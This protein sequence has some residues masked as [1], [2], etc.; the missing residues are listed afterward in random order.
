MNILVPMAGVR[1]TA[2]T[3]GG[4]PPQLYE[5]AGKTIIQRVI[6]NL[7]TYGGDAR[8]IFI[9]RIEDCEKY[10]LHST[11]GLILGHKAKV[12]KVRGE[13]GGAACSA[14]LAIS[15]INNTSP[16]V[17]ANSD[18]ILD[19]NFSDFLSTSLKADAAVVTFSSVHPRWSYVRME[20]MKVT[21]AVEKYPISNHA[22]AGMYLF[23]E[24]RD[25][26]RAA[27]SSI[28]QH[29]S[30]DGVFFIA[31]IL[32]QLILEGKEIIAYKISNESYHTLYTHEKIR[33]YEIHLH[34][35]IHGSTAAI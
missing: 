23:R 30:V 2:N 35:D 29:C 13:T 8:F 27:M 4:Y 28:R 21:E 11:I 31:P 33:E 34:S 16:L 26:V 3:L 6:E 32:N 20:Q 19:V 24:G 5:I 25:F 9:L 15:E 1:V 18:Q 12:I 22:I 17:I 7:S 10:H 14:L